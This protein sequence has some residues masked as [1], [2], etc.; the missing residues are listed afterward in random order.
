MI[1]RKN[2]IIMKVPYIPKELLHI[3][4]DYEGSIKYNY[5]IFSF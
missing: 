1:E 4:L 3:L 5:I 2:I